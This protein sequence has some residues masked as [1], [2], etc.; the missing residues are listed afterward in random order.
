MPHGVLY[1]GDL[2]PTRT[3]LQHPLG[4]HLL[5]MVSQIARS[6]PLNPLKRTPSHDSP[7][8]SPKKFHR[9]ASSSLASLLPARPRGFRPPP[10]RTSASFG[11]MSGSDTDS[12]RPSRPP[13]IA[14]VGGSPS[15][16]RASGRSSS[17]S[18]L[19]PPS[20]IPFDAAWDRKRGAG[21]ALAR[22]MNMVLPRIYVGSATAA[23]S[24]KLLSAHGVT[25]VLNCCTLPNAHEGKPGA[26]IYLQLHLSDSSADLPRL[27]AALTQGVAFIRDALASGGVVL[28]HCHAGISRSCSVAIAYTVWK[29]KGISSEDAF[30]VIRK[31]RTQCDPNLSYMC[32]LKDWERSVADGTV[33]PPV[34]TAPPVVPIVSRRSRSV[35]AA[36]DIS[37]ASSAM[38]TLCVS[39]APPATIRAPQRPH[40]PAGASRLCR[41]Y[42]F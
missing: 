16:T 5:A 33:D 32:A 41:S 8:S 14:D 34:F 3:C 24:R 23:G 28:V 35:T 36:R 39:E 10:I 31:S 30:E 40:S 42:S 26:P 25:H 21:G 20:R 4:K 1:F 15:V 37:S 19:R 27:G 12:P 2:A 7:R 17:R 38:Q 11:D 9:R 22:E 13:R 6:S 18:G 29:Q